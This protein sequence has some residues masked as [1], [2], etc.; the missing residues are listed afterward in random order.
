MPTLSTHIHLSHRP[1]RSLANPSHRDWR[2]SAW[3]TNLHPSGSS[4]SSSTAPTTAAQATVSHITNPATTTG[5]IPTASDSSDEDQDCTCPHCDRTSP[6]ASACSVTCES[7][8][9][10]RANQYLEH[11]P[12]P[13]APASTA[14]TVL[15]PSRIAWAYSAT[16]A[17][18]RTVTC[19]STRP[20]SRHSHRIQH[21]HCAKPNTCS[22]ALRTRHHYHYHHHRLRCR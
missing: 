7:I 20:Q 12:T 15:A 11:Q 18:T 19:A 22:I 21:V 3:S 17:S 13:T 1:A 8:A 9:R 14:H 6:H 4:S 5:T 16:C 10:R 2:T